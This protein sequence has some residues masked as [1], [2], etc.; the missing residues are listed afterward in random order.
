MIV[1]PEGVLTFIGKNLISFREL[2]RAAIDKGHVLVEDADKISYLYKV[3]NGV[4]ESLG[5]MIESITL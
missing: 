1:H 4:L 5:H 2:D 3:A